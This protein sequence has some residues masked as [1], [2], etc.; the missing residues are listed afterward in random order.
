MD[1]IAFGGDRSKNE[2]WHQEV[3][4]GKGGRRRKVEVAEAAAT[5]STGKGGLEG[6]RLAKSLEVPS[7]QVGNWAQA[8]KHLKALDDSILGH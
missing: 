6:A 1:L 4:P 7:F 5:R 2:E 3:T 8:P